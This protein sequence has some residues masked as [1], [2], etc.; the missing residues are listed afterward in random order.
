MNTPASEPK[1]V[2]IRLSLPPQALK[3]QQGTH[4]AVKQSATKR[5]RAEA[6]LEAMIIKQKAGAFTGPVVVSHTWYL[7]PNNYEKAMGKDTPK[8]FRT[9][10]P[11]DEGNAIA[12]LKPAIDGIVDSGLIIDDRAS[13][14]RWGDFNRLSTFRETGGKCGVIITITEQAQ[15]KKA[16]A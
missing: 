10:K 12:A 5:Y 9:Y 6:Q 15:E 16:D 8:K 13:L 7:A 11:R 3:A 14:L 2:S 4:P 1:T